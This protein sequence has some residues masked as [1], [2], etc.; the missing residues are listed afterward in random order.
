M[1]QSE[2]NYTADIKLISVSLRLSYLPWEFPQIFLTLVYI[3]PGANEN[4][5]CE[6]IHQVTHK[7]Y[8]HFPW[9]HLILF[10]V[11]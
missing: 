10:L 1:S 2:R 5:A 9:M 3:H 6:F 7:G 4:T 8:N 11:I